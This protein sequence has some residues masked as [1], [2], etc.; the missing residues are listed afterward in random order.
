MAEAAALTICRSR[1]EYAGGRIARGT[2]ACNRGF[3]PVDLTPQQPDACGQFLNRQQRQVLS[4]LMRCRLP[5]PILIIHR[6]RD[7]LLSSKGCQP[8]PGWLSNWFRRRLRCSR[9]QIMDKLPAQMTVVA[10][11]KP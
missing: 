1:L 10:I 7:D 4:D 11:S 9:G 8:R 3:Q 2:L 6:H 5:R